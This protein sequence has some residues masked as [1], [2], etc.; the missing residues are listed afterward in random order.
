M[1]GIDAGHL[2]E[3]LNTQGWAHYFLRLTEAIRGEQRRLESLDDITEVRRS[4]GFLKGLRRAQQRRKE[5]RFV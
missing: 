4:Q 5:T 2:Q 3:T 1:D